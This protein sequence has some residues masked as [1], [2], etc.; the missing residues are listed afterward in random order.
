MLFVFENLVRK[1]SVP[2]SLVTRDRGTYQGG[3]YVPGEE[4]TDEINAAVI[5]MSQ[6]KIY[7]SG[8]HLTG[9][10]REMFVLKEKDRID[11]T[12]GRTYFLEH[13]GRKYK[14]EEAGLYGEDYADFN[15]YTLKRVDSFDV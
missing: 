13:N 8:G 7:Q 3:D 2:C 9:E 15:H 11:L 4:T 5:S 14:V 1:Y 10:D 12:D 6:Q